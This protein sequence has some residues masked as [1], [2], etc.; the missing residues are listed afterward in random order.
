MKRVR[1][2][3]PVFE[4]KNWRAG[5]AGASGKET[6]GW[7]RGEG[8]GDAGLPCGEQGGAPFSWRT[9]VIRPRQWV[10]GQSI[11]EPWSD[12][13]RGRRGRIGGDRCLG[14]LTQAVAQCAASHNEPS[15]R[16]VSGFHFLSPRAPEHAG[17]RVGKKGG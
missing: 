9:G 6:R 16:P 14:I 8:G 3:V 10:P 15:G 5:Q 4:G 1:G 7:R 11:F 12:T 13:R 17:L 2:M